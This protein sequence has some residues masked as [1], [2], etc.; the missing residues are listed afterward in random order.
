[1][2]I[3]ELFKDKLLE[4]EMPVDSGLWDKLNSKMNAANTS[5]NVSSGQMSKI[6]NAVKSMSLAAKTIIAVVG[7]VALAVTGIVLY[8][9]DETTENP[10]TETSAQ[11]NETKIDDN[12]LNN[13]DNNLLISSVDTNVCTEKMIKNNDVLNDIDFDIQSEDYT[14]PTNEDII[15]PPEI[16]ITQNPDP[17]ILHSKSITDSNRQNENYDTMRTSS[18]N[19]IHILIPN[20]IT[21]NADGINDCFE[22]KHIENY[23]DNKLI[24]YTR[25]GKIV[26]Q[27]EHYNNEFCPQNVKENVYYYKLTVRNNGLTK[28][29]NGIINIIL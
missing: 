14:F 22:I 7:T 2:N 15:T 20:V 5:P 1:M 23:M 27:K 24:I 21:P 17:V 12:D 9:N 8:N 18:Y 28:D 11:N 3:E 16:M 26:Y 6:I 4:S 10:L 13:N 29:F 19:E 25:Q